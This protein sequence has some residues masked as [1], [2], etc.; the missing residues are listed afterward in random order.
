MKLLYEVPQKLAK[1]T[2]MK[3]EAREGKAEIKISKGSTRASRD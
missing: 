2:G 1:E 3:V